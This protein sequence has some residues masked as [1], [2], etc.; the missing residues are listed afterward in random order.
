MKAFLA[1]TYEIKIKEEK[2]KRKRHTHL[3]STNRRIPSKTH[4]QSY[5]SNTVT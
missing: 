4:T 3:Y 5:Y 1:F 2:K